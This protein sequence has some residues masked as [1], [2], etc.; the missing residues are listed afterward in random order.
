MEE[1][2]K[3]YAEQQEEL[4]RQLKELSK[5]KQVTVIPSR[6]RRLKKFGGSKSEDFEGW[7]IDARGAIGGPGLSVADKADFLVSRLEGSARREIM[8]YSDSVAEAK[9]CVIV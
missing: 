9:R 5:A 6:D 3:K 7:E 4:Q 2:D 1:M 8:C